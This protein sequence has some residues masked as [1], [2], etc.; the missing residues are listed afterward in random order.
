MATLRALETS[1]RTIR[2]DAR[3]I[4]AT[5]KD[6]RHLVEARQFRADLF[7]RLNVFPVELPPLRERREDIPLL[8]E[9]FVRQVADRIGRP[10]PEVPPSVF[11][12]IVERPWPGNIR[13]IENFIQRAVILSENGVLQ[14]PPFEGTMRTPKFNQ[15]GACTLREIDREYIL[16]VLDTTGWVVGGSTG[17]AAILGLPRTTL[18][19][20]M[21]KLGIRRGIGQGTAE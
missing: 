11:A 19:T 17:A 5:N 15:E 1:M 16:R 9:H 21:A 7:Y 18:I 3:V 20:K 6:L 2:V 8:V 10:K 12:A 14:L 13:E 4:A